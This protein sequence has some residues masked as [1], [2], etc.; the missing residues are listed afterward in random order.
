MVPVAR[1]NLFAEKGRFAISVAGVG[2]AVL[3]IVTV[4]ALYRGWSR[5]GQIFQEMPG[6][7]WVVQQGTSDPFHSVSLLERADLERTASVPGVEAVVPVMSRQMTLSA[8][9]SEETGRSLATYR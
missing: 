3:L 6:Q 8:G 5:T 7:L 9:G 1:R 4:L 2:F